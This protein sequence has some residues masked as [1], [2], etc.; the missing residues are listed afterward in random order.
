MPHF[1][2]AP[3]STHV[4]EGVVVGAP[5]V[6]VAGTPVLHGQTRRY[7]ASASSHLP[8]SLKMHH[9]SLLIPGATVEP[10][11]SAVPALQLMST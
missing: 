10:E 5:V 11:A 6:V 7:E 9:S 8:S 4:I 1:S 2:P 3:P